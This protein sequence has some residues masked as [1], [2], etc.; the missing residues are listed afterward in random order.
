MHTT[1]GTAHLADKGSDAAVTP[2]FQQC[3]I[4]HPI[5]EVDMQA[6][7]RCSHPDRRPLRRALRPSATAVL[8]GRQFVHDV[9]AVAVK[10]SI[11]QTL[12]EFMHRFV[13]ETLA[14]HGGEPAR[15]AVHWQACGEDRRAGDAYRQAADAA[16][17]LS[18]PVEQ[19]QMLDAAVACHERCAANDALFDVLL[20]RQGGTGAVPTCAR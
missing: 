7:S 17:Q 19:C 4:T 3:R 5:D 10:R 20:A 12:T 15:M 18:R 6:F 9:I 13:A 2:R 14:T 11:A 1:M 16:A 8:F